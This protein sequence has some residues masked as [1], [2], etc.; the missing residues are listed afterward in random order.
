MPH[1][2]LQP[3]VR[4]II[5]GITNTFENG[6]PEYAYGKC[7][8]LDDGRG[9]TCGR[10]G[11]TTGTGDALWVVEKYVQQ[12]TNASLAQYLPELR[13]L[14]AL[15]SCDTTGKENIQQL[16][17]LPAAW[18]A[19]DREDAA[20]FRRVQDSINEEHYLVPALKFAH[21][22]GVVTPLGQAIFYDTVV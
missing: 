15:P 11:F 1:T 12:R 6:T 18:A 8:H 7:E 9:Y 2:R 5:E 3:L 10:I 14:A 4:R 19:A 16:Q 22:Y 17:G 20:L 21:K 13:R